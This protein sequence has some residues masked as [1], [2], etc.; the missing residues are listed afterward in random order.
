MEPEDLFQDGE[1]RGPSI[2][3]YTGKRWYLL[4]PRPE[5]VDIIDIAHALAGINRWGGH[6]VFPVSVAAHSLQVSQYCCPEHRLQGLLHDAAEAYLGGVSRPLKGLLPEYK[7]LENRTLAVIFGALGVKP[8]FCPCVKEADDAMLQYEYEECFY[9]DSVYP[10]LTRGEWER[11][12]L[13]EFYF[14]YDRPWR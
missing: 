10:R 11:A 2:T 1:G 8:T 7:P 5:E 4:D 12:F 14:Q 9:D 6:T 3:T 13:D